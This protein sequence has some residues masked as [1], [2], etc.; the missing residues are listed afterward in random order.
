MKTSLLCKAALLTATAL[1]LVSG[2]TAENATEEETS[3]V[4]VQSQAKPESLVTALLTWTS[5]L[6]CPA[7]NI[8][9]TQQKANALMKYMMGGPSPFPSGTGGCMNLLGLISCPN[10][11]AE[12]KYAIDDM[13][14]KMDSPKKD[15]L[16]NQTGVNTGAC[17]WTNNALNNDCGVSI[18]TMTLT[19]NPDLITGLLSWGF[20][21]DL[22]SDFRAATSTWNGTNAM[23]AC[24]GTQG[25]GR[26]FFPGHFSGNSVP[27]DPEPAQAQIALSGSNGAT[28]AAVYT[29]SLTATSIVKWPSSYIVGSV[30]AG[31]PCSPVDLTLGSTTAH[32]IQAVGSY[33]K[34][35]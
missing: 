34:C 8:G 3:N 35:Y 26:F 15:W 27:I 33:R 10:A 16:G 12:A 6:Q 9:A 20:G 29:T 7:S 5:G 19:C 17:Q 28:A 32:V 22:D 2:C 11:C 4:E 30:P 24:F 1:V 21:T 18:A 25:L 23:D 31:L 14:A 13:K